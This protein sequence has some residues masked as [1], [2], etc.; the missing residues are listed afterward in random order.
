LQCP[1]ALSSS[2]SAVARSHY[3]LQTATIVALGSCHYH[4]RVKRRTARFALPPRRTAR[5]ESELGRKRVQDTHWTHSAFTSAQSKDKSR[6]DQRQERSKARSKHRRTHSA[7]TAT[8]Q[9]QEQ[10]AEQTIGRTVVPTHHAAQAHGID[11]IPPNSERIFEACLNRD[12]YTMREPALV[13]NKR[14]RDVS[15]NEEGISIRDD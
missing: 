11:S 5:Q 6:A 12:A 10:S 7:F 4:A 9:R 8:E 1:T 15:R 2:R 14:G 13:S 3:S